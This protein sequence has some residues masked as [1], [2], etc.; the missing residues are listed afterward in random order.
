MSA[1]NGEFKQVAVEIS[2]S[3]SISAKTQD[4]HLFLHSICLFLIVL[5]PTVTSYAITII[6]HTDWVLTLNGKNI[7]PA[8]DA[9]GPPDG[10][11]GR[12]EAKRAFGTDPDTGV[13]ATISASNFTA[14]TLKIKAS[15]K[16]TN[17][18][19]K[20]DSVMAKTSLEFTRIYKTKQVKSTGTFYV[21][22]R[23]DIK[24]IDGKLITQN[25]FFDP[26]AI[27]FLKLTIEEVNA[28]G[29]PLPL[30]GLQQPI[31]IEE[32]LDNT[33]TLIP[34][35]VVRGGSKPGDKHTDPGNSQR[36]IKNNFNGAVKYKKKAGET[37][38]FQVEGEFV[39]DVDIGV[40]QSL[41]ERQ[42][43]LASFMEFVELGAH[44]SLLSDNALLDRVSK[45]IDFGT[46]EL[47]P[48][49]MSGFAEA[50]FFSTVDLIV[51]TTDVICIPPGI[52]LLLLS[53]SGFVE[54]H[55]RISSELG[56]TPG[57]LWQHG[58]ANCGPTPG[59]TWPYSYSD[60]YSDNLIRGYEYNLSHKYL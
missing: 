18:S 12:A 15:A 7:S 3:R 13:A 45:L 57:S 28:S 10:P 59:Y 39:V 21:N 49:G 29:E 26:T 14:D 38:Y 34:N 46:G 43:A 48:A 19:T 11:L 50:D 51:D 53:K 54:K 41:Q 24:G 55:D 35:Q 36:T 27:M 31:F 40:V 44:G 30:G 1:S 22:M 20:I 16:V 37:L 33:L 60:T 58:T 42:V 52:L 17:D 5:L 56:R 2:V 23:G 47:T 8:Q 32:F 4:N 6:P 9:P 25:P